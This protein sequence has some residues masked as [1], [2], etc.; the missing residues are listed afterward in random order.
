VD[1][2]PAEL[3]RCN[4]L[5]RGVSLTTGRHMWNF[6]SAYYSNR[7]RS[8]SWDWTRHHRVQL[9]FY[10]NDNDLPFLKRWILFFVP[11]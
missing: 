9:P 10:F 4:L 11:G 8:R 2:K 5:V 7:F 3:L 1:G 6:N